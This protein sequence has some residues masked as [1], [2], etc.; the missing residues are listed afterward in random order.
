MLSVQQM[1]EADKIAHDN[2]GSLSQVTKEELRQRD[3][4]IADNY[5][6]VLKMASQNHK[7]SLLMFQND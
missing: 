3:Q 2:Q 4:D 7:Q 6:H 1:D 5:A